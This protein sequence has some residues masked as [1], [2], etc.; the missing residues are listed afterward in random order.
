MKAP[1]LKDYLQ[2]KDT[3]HLAVNKTQQKFAKSFKRVPQTYSE[4]NLL[5]FGDKVMMLNKKTNGFLV[6]DMG[7]RITSY[8][9]AY[10]VTTTN[11]NIAPCARSIFVLSRAEEGDGFSDETLHYGQKVRLLANPWIH[12][13]KLYLHSCPISP[14]AYARFSRHQE[15][16][17][18]TKLVYNTAF[19]VQ[20]PDPRE[21]LEA[22]GQQVLANSPVLLKHCATNHFLASD[23]LKC[24]N[25]FGTEFEVNCHSY[26]TNNKSQNLALENTGSITPESAT[27]FQSDENMW[28]FVTAPDPSYSAPVEEEAEYTVDDLVRDI[29][30]KL[31]ERGSYGIRGLA[32]VFKNMDDKGDRKVDVEDFRWG[33]V[34]YGISITKDQASQV[35]TRFDR[36]KD[37]TV[38]FDEFLRFLKGD[39]NEFREKLIRLAYGKLDINGDGQVTLEDIAKLYDATHH[40]DVSN[41]RLESTCNANPNIGNCKE[42]DRGRG[43]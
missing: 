11:N 20:H 38:C 39:I 14:Q 30:K 21:R 12:H 8:D 24:R 10:G 36:D 22:N 9:E 37:G 2:K 41:T 27:K 16:C 34:D 35:L 15:V 26:G 31:L 40:P 1:R 19:V 33:L 18:H 7:D 25:D 6:L 32:R 42:E 4:D 23:T 13:K 43:V 5:R 3:N 29:K 17:M 28:M